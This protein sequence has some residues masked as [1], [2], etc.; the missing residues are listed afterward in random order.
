MYDTVAIGGKGFFVV[1]R[2]LLLNVSCLNIV[3]HNI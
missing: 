1:T 3:I 2:G